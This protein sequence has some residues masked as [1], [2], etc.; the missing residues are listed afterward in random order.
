METAEKEPIVQEEE[1]TP[2]AS[3]QGA[4]QKTAQEA[5]KDKSKKKKNREEELQ[6]KLEEA[7]AFGKKQKEQLLR[8]A[9][10]YDNFRKR[11]EREKSAVYADATADAVKE[12]LN[13]ADNLERALA[14]QEC[15]VEDLRKGGEMVQ[16]QM[17]AALDKLGVTA[18]GEVG[19]A[20]DPAVHN[21][22]SH[23]EDEA[24]GDNVVTQ[25]FQKGYKIGDKVIRYAMVQVAN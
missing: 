11:T 17:C 6:Q 1:K 5:K 2:E 16:A 18:M 13:V 19:E 15:S 22:V 7:E 10:E 3:E 9:A 21:A 14:Q 12:I 23:V 20:F 4:E 24:A 8:T 25:V